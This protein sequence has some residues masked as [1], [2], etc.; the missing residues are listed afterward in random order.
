[1]SSRLSATLAAAVFGATTLFTLGNA[2]SPTVS[3]H[4]PVITHPPSAFNPLTASATQ[5]QEYGFP[6]RPT[7]GSA[8]AVWLTAM[9]AVHVSNY[10]YS[11][12]STSSAVPESGA[13]ATNSSCTQAQ[14]EFGSQPASSGGYKTM[15]WQYNSSTSADYDITPYEDYW[16]NGTWKPVAA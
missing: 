1:M 9:K 6:P 16:L 8:L 11:V 4:S 10:S 5:L 7:G 12:I 15:I 14:S 2:S 13:G 3:S